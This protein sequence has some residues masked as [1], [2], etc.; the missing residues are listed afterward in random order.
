MNKKYGLLAGL[1]AV[2]LLTW[3][4]IAM[5]LWKQRSVSRYT[6]WVDRPN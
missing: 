6:Y 4:L 5:I 2:N 3:F 1:V